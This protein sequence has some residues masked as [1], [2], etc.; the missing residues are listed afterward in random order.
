M[1]INDWK[2]WSKDLWKEAENS[3][4]SRDGQDHFYRNKVI[5]P[6]L[7]KELRK[8]TKL[9]SIVD[10]GCGDAYVLDRLLKKRILR[11]DKTSE[12]VLIDRSK[13][14]IK[15]AKSRLHVPSLRS[16]N[17]DLDDETWVSMV[18]NTK[19]NRLFLSIF[20]IQ[21]MPRLNRLISNLGKVLGQGDLGLFITVAPFFAN[22]LMSSGKMHRELKSSA[23]GHFK[24]AAAYPI[25]NNSRPLYLP[26]FH[27]T[28]KEYER[29]LNK[30]GMK[31]ENHL[32]LSVP[33]SKYSRQIFEN[34]LYGSA[35]FN[36]PSSMLLLVKRK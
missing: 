22:L 7:E 24:W 16:V 31:L 18:R 33:D 15:I 20:L 28:K 6:A 26:Y 2:A 8:V 27:R 25:A 21:E 30:Y 14:L 36:K 19:P 23:N 17:A 1:R 11:A 34:T 3:W 12:I 32:Y 13:R 9:R 35:I 4:I 10:L 29:I 5:I